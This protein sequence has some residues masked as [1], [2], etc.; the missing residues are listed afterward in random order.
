M[1]MSK[2]IDPIIDSWY[3]S[4]GFPECFKVI[5][6]DEDDYVEIQY[7]D[8]ELDKLDFETWDALHPEEIAIPEDPDAPYQLDKEADV[9][10]LLNE[11]E[12]Q[13]DLEEHLHNL[14]TD[15]ETWMGE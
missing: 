9:L 14:D 15:D 6:F 10:S 8:G 1:C 13:A 12:E 11:V 7:L 3:D 5:D 2:H 4:K